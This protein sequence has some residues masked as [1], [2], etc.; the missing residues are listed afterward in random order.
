MGSP[1]LKF[2][3]FSKAPNPAHGTKRDPTRLRFMRTFDAKDRVFSDTNVEE[4][5]NDIDFREQL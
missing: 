1:L 5:D 3:E 2:D 4:S